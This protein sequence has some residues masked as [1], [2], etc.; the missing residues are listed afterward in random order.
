MSP[1]LLFQIASMTV[2]P[3]WLALALAPLAP[4]LCDVIASVV[5]PLLL[6]LA[7]V[8]LILAHWSSSPGGFGTLPEVIALLSYPPTAVA[9]WI[10]FLAF[11][12]FIGA[13]ITRTARA[14]SIHHGLVLP[15][16]ALTFLFGPAGFL[17]FSI[18]R[19]S[20]SGPRSLA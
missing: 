16:L 15:C 3:G 19:L 11:D 9:G 10:H 1:D 4:R 20:L 7:Y 12:L 2:L 14:G 6:A 17:A 5:I 18:L 8:G 13:W